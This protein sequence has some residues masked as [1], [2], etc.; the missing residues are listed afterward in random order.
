MSTLPDTFEF[1]D[2]LLLDDFSIEHDGK[3]DMTNNTISSCPSCKIQL[4]EG[5]DNTYECSSCGYISTHSIYK[6]SE[7]SH[8]SS[9][10]LPPRVI[11]KHSMRF[12]EMI[13]KSNLS[14]NKAISD[15]LRTAQESSDILKQYM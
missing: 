3:K 4:H 7:E 11:G 2:K 1:D 5:G 14:S 6:I 8:S 10:Y 13:H 15:I 12:N 9:S